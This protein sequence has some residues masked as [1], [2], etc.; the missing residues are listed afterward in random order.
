MSKNN[1]IKRVLNKRKKEKALKAKRQNKKR[2]PKSFSPVMTMMD[3]PLS[4]LTEEQRKKVID[5]IGDGNKKTYQEALGKIRIILEKYD[6]V[7]LISIMACYGLTTG[8]GDKGVESKEK[9][10]NLNQSHVEVLQ[11][12]FLQVEENKNGWEAVTPDV[13]QEIWDTLTD[14][15]SSHP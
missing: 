6:S 3:N 1:K 5:E 11:A 12:L 2:L 8:A 14:L 10:G 15:S 4:G 9:Y 13:V 7:M